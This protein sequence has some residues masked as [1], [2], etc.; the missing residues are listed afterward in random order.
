MN[1]PTYAAKYYD[2]EWIYVENVY[3]HF[4]I[5]HM[6]DILFYQI[7]HVLDT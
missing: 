7:Q 1:H 5:G 6:L 3:N 4:Y 2:I